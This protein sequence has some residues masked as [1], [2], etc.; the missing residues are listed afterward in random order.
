MIVT[1]L[2]ASVGL[3]LVGPKLGSSRIMT[4]IKSVDTTLVRIPSATPYQMGAMARGASH[5][6]SIIVRVE[7]IQPPSADDPSVIAER[8]Q[9]NAATRV[10]SCAIGVKTTSE[11][12]LFIL[13]Q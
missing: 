8:E 10:A 9:I 6:M 11:T 4:A 1:M 12:L 13:P 2:A 3:L 5:A 7:N